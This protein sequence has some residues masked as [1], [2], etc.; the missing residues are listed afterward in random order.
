MKIIAQTS[1]EHLLRAIKV[2]TVPYWVL[3]GML[4]GWVVSCGFTNELFKTPST[5]RDLVLSYVWIKDFV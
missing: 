3:G 4:G 2:S 5:N 1:T